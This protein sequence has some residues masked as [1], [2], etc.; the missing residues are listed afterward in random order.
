MENPLSTTDRRTPLGR[1]MTVN[2]TSVVAIVSWD[3]S[4]F[5]RN[6]AC[7]GGSSRTVW[8]EKAP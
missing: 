1:S 2:S 5:H 6:E 7:L 3:S 4:R 8:M